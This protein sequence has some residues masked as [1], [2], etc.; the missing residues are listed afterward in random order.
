ME[1]N[2]IILLNLWADLT[3]LFEVVGIVRLPAG[4]SCVIV[5]S[6]E[7]WGSK[8]FV[9]YELQSIWVLNAS[10]LRNFKSR[11][12]D[13]WK[14]YWKSSNWRGL[15]LKDDFYVTFK[16]RSSDVVSTMMLLTKMTCLLN[17]LS[18]WKWI[19]QED[20]FCNE[21]CGNILVLV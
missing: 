10:W 19:D 15:C 21:Y 14:F 6:T 8:H 13:L 16:G 4:D 2:G 1:C 20:I 12:I 18:E 17:S 11:W 9:V 3:Q 7:W 5:W